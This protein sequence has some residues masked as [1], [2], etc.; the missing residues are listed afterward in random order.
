M[1]HTECLFHTILLFIYLF[2][3]AQVG[4]R[5]TCFTFDDYFLAAVHIVVRMSSEA[6]VHAWPAERVVRAHQVSCRWVGQWRHPRRV[7]RS[8]GRMQT[9]GFLVSTGHVVYTRHRHRRTSQ[10]IAWV[11]PVSFGTLDCPPSATPCLQCSVAF[12][13]SSCWQN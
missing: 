9:L 11:F 5:G 7:R 10:T 8:S 12:V 1:T 4:H 2:L 3:F 13:G 6:D